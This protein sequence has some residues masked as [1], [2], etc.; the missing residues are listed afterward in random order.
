MIDRIRYR[1]DTQ[2]VVLIPGFLCGDPSMGRLAA[3]LEAHGH[4]PY[5]AGMV[6]NVDCSEA[7]LRRLH[8]LVVELAEHHQAPVALVGHSRG[9]L[10]GRVI[11]HRSP[12]L[13]S[14]V[15]TL[16]TP[17]QNPWRV[18]PGLVA[19]ALA[20]SV[21]GSF[22]LPGI[23]SASCA[24]AGSCCSAFWRDLRAPLPPA[25]RLLSI[26]STTDRIVDWRACLDP[27]GRHAE[28]TAGHHELPGHRW[29]LRLVVDAL[30]ATEAARAVVAADP[31][32]RRA[33]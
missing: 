22:G 5:P 14:A 21:L 31:S 16:G 18:H 8:R 1:P 10:F 6:C 7:A 32:A 20:L 28:V 2:P 17:H 3:F 29:A 12:E 25:V 13:V 9:G 24:V 33:A 15:V 23:M 26:Y 11:A 30:S 19:Q 4:R 27:D